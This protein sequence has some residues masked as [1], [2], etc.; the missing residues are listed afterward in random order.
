MYGYHYTTAQALQA[1]RY[2]GH[3]SASRH[4]DGRPV[5]FSLRAWLTA[6]RQQVRSAMAR[7]LV[8]SRFGGPGTT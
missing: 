5:G 1:E 6:G 8:I 7:R 3:D 2:R 4:A